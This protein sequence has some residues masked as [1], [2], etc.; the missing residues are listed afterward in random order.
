MCDYAR[1]PM[2]SRADHGTFSS[3]PAGGFVNPTISPPWPVACVSRFPLE[4]DGREECLPNVQQSLV[5][6]AEAAEA[7]HD[8]TGDVAGA[9]CC[10]EMTTLDLGQPVA[11]RAGASRGA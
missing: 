5:P 3:S 8:E 1:T 6:V 7:G 9:V 11:M 2:S 10:D 4:L